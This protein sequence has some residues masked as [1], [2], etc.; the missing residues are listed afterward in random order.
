[1]FYLWNSWVPSSPSVWII[2]Q[3]LRMAASL[4]NSAASSF[5]QHGET[6]ILRAETAS[7]AK[8]KTLAGPSLQMKTPESRNVGID[9]LNLMELFCT[10]STLRWP[11]P[12]VM[13]KRIFRTSMANSISCRLSGG[14]SS[15]GTP[16][17]PDLA[18]SKVSGQHRPRTASS[19][20]P[21]TQT[22][23]EDVCFICCSLGSNCLLG[24]D[25]LFQTWQIISIWWDRLGLHG[26]LVTEETDAV[27]F[28]SQLFP[29]ID[30]LCRQKEGESQVK[31]K[32]LSP[33]K[34]STGG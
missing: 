32:D 28:L 19:W 31:K 25:F 13:L 5:R 29:D 14:N 17:N 16:S 4:L 30:S 20:F 1:M 10:S 34:K 26:T 24:V 33:E 11:L 6:H 23:P 18:A 3:C 27:K 12:N 21:G 22:G 9:A 8:T 7:T 15:S 2:R